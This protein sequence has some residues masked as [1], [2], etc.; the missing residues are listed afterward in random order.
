[1]TRPLLTPSPYIRLGL[2]GYNTSGG[3]GFTTVPERWPGD[4]DSNLALAT[5]AEEAGIDFM[6]PVARYKGYGGLSDYQGSVLDPVTWA[7]GLLAATKRMSVFATVHTAFTHPVLAAKQFATLD[8]IGHGRF[9]LNVVCGWNSVEYEMFGLQLPPEHEVRY[10]IGEEW[11]TIVQKIWEGGE[12]FDFD[13]RHYQLKDV[14]GRP[15]PFG[16]T[17]P[18]LMNAGASTEGRAF[19]ARYSDI[20]FTSML[21][22][23]SS[24][25]QLVAHKALAAGFGKAAQ[26]MTGSFVVCRPTRKEAEDYVHYYAVEKGDPEGVERLMAAQQLTGKSFPPELFKELKIRFAAG[27]GGFPLVGTPD[28]VADCIERVAKA[29]FFGLTLGFV[30][31]LRDFPYVRDEVFPRLEKRGLR[32][33]PVPELEVGTLG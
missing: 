18:P 5:M 19:S 21:D 24:A 13:G 14:S 20:L 25:P 26:V 17:P 15:G 23:E 16:G 30:N 28:D 10:S 9:A 8:A 27:H 2:F 4:W 22:P 32:A 12:P 6:I 33:P 29:G 7:A 31:A 1:M 3:S 11:L